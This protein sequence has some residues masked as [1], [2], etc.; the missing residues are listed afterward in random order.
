MVGF[1]IA[2]PTLH[3]KLHKKRLLRN[4]VGMVGFAIALPTLHKKR[5]LRNRVF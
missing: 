2:L 3:K 4:R 1:A 5:L